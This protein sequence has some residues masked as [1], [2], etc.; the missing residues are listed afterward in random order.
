M[1]KTLIY[2]V[3]KP[4]LTVKDMEISIEDA[5]TRREMFELIGL[6]YVQQGNIIYFEKLLVAMQE[7][8][9][10]PCITSRL[11]S[12]VKRRVDVGI[13]H[14]ADQW[15]HLSNKKHIK[16]NYKKYKFQTKK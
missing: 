8:H 16:V 10:E 9:G 1:S 4:V 11:H 13:L 2:I 5:E 3:E 7:I 12:A 15:L 6:M 14:P